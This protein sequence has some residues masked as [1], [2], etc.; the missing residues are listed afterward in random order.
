MRNARQRPRAGALPACLAVATLLLAGCRD[1]GSREEAPE[2]PGGAPGEAAAGAAAAEPPAAP[3]R[4]ITIPWVS[5]D[6]TGALARARQAGLPVFVD[7]W[8]P[9]CHTCLSMKQVVMVD[10]AMAPYLDRFIWLEIDTDKPENAPVLETL[11]IEVWPTL[12]VVS[13]PPEGGGPQEVQV[14]ARHLGAASV[15]QLRDVLEQGE[16]GH[17]DAMAAAGQLDAASPLGRVRAGDRAAA[18]GDH[19]AADRAYGEA[20]A[21]APADWPRTADVLVKQIAARYRAGDLAGCADLA[22]R[23][24]ERAALGATASVTDFAYYGDRCAAALDDPRARLLRGRLSDAIRKVV[25]APDAAMSVD[26]RSDALRVM[27]QI[28]HDFGDEETAREIA[29]RQRALLDRAAAEAPSAMARM[30]YNWPRAEVYM[31]LGRA[32]ELIPDIER[33]VAELPEEYDPPY[34]LAGLY[35][36]VGRLDDAMKMAERARGLIYGPRKARVLILIADI[37]RARG[38]RAAE[39]RARQEVVDYYESLPPGHRSDKGL[40]AARAALAA[41]G[42]QPAPPR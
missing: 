28:A 25:D 14:Q 26:D 5:D 11:A 13:P 37:H 31:Y 33:S 8:A 42:K 23:E 10:P 29:E 35:L 6:W 7:L 22:M 24:A 38:D 2:P 12:Y 9:W 36:E 17:L 30:T 19:A 32:A 1:R 34:R 15:A 27:R 18:A 4:P 40:A 21:A 20:L 3:R 39:K 16:K 41:V